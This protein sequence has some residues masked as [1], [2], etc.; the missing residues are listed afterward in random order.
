MGVGGGREGPSEGDPGDWARSH[1]TCRVGSSPCTPSPHPHATARAAAPPPTPRRTHR[2]MPEP[3]PG[4]PRSRSER[5]VPGLAGVELRAATSGPAQHELPQRQLHERP[6][7][8]Q[9]E[10]QPERSARLGQP[11]A[12]GT[13]TAAAATAAARAPLPRPRAAAR[14]L[15]RPL[16]A[17]PALPSDAV[18]PH[19]RR[20][21]APLHGHQPPP[22][23]S[24]PPRLPAAASAPPR[25]RTETAK[26]QTCS[27]WPVLPS[28]HHH[29]QHHHHLPRLLWACL[30]AR[31]AQAGRGGFA[32]CTSTGLV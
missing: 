31:P 21:R 10:R 1:N 5:S 2:W 24:S 7:H 20:L 8:Q 9:V 17:L 28:H 22:T 26:G 4:G 15:R 19:G 14:R 6:Q 18:P 25:A 32:L 3:V 30:L 12:T 23:A 29:H 13:A 27:H 16:R 11:R